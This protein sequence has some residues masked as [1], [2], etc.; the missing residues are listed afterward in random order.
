MCFFKDSLYARSRWAI[1]FPAMDYYIFCTL[2][3]KCPSLLY[4][5]TFTCISE[6]VFL[7]NTTFSRKPSLPV[8]LIPI[9]AVSGTFSISS[10]EICYS[11][12]RTLY[13]VSPLSVCYQV[14]FSKS[15]FYLFIA[16]YLAPSIV[17]SK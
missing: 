11:T 6:R 10:I 14:A 12:P 5:H 4:S 17:T 8:Y 2:F 7:K 15:T 13:S 3:L 1:P 16:R 9:H